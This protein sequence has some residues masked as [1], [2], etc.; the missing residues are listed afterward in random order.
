MTTQALER[1]T[2]G[3]VAEPNPLIAEAMKVEG[4]TLTERLQLIDKV[5]EVYWKRQQVDAEA[6]YSAAMAEAQREMG[7][8]VA[9][10]KNL[11]T[12]SRY[13]KYDAVDK[14]IRPI[15][16]KHGFALSFKQGDDAPADHIRL[17]CRV[18][19]SGG[20]TEYPH[21]DMPTD[22]KGAKGGE[23]MT[24]MHAT[25]SGIAYGKRYLAGMI[26]NLAITEEDN[27]GNQVKP[28]ITE[29]QAADLQA[30]TE[31][32]AADVDKF[33]KYMGVKSISEIPAD[34][35]AKAVKALEKKRKVAA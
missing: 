22:G 13:A 8:I 4:L 12:H 30:L 16:S 31:E 29:K 34:A 10:A 32:V 6:A 21:L 14:V 2:T 7:P 19:H 20:H 23:V 5:E 11:Q 9:N 28:R 18:S 26:F 3:V 35:Y 15:Y 27:D 17:V 25:G 1:R 33:C 24:K